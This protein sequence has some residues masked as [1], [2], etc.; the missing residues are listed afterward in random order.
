V[1]GTDDDYKY[2]FGYRRFNVKIEIEGQT[3]Y[4]GTSEDM[5]EVEDGSVSFFITSPPYWNLK[6]YGHEDQVGAEGYEEYLDRLDTV[7]K[8][9]FRKG[10][11]DAVLVVNVNSRRHKYRFYPIAFDIARTITGWKL[12]DV[13]VW[14]IPNA[15]PQPNHYRERLFD[16]KFEY[17]LVFIKGD[18]RGYTFHKPR[19]PQKYRTADPRDHKKN[20][21]GRCLGNVLRIPAYRPPNIKKLGYHVAAY[22]EELVA[23]MLETYTDPG[24]VVLDPFLGS[25]TTLKVCRVM[26][27]RGIGYEINPDFQSLIKARIQEDWEVPDWNTIDVINS[28]TA[29]PGMLRGPR[30]IQYTRK[31]RTKQPS[32]G[33]DGLDSELPSVQESLFKGI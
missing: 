17:L 16:N 13:L 14:Y 29:E 26:G 20:P 9:C 25:G 27:R 12:W 30:K 28:T 4:F 5:N 1:L 23:L 18:P 33:S 22:P 19:V 10:T 6:N 11:D 8:Q 31:N 15:L 2:R 24:D 7:W 3:V 32:R 21:R